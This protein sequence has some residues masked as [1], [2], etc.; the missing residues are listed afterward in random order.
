MGEDGKE[1][2]Y[3]RGV[4]PPKQRRSE[5]T[6]DRLLDG[7]ESLLDGRDFEDIPVLEIAETAGIS[8]SSL[9]ARFKN[10]TVLLECLYER[11]MERIRAQV[12]D[13]DTPWQGFT[14]EEI[15]RELARR[16][17]QHRR[18]HTGFLRTMMLVELRDPRFRL[19]RLKADAL[20]YGAVRDFVLARWPGSDP[21]ERRRQVGFVLQLVQAALQNLFSTPEVLAEAIDADDAWI[22]DEIA[23]LILRYLEVAP[24]GD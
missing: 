9:Y 19:W 24:R 22:A 2:Q 12:L 14:P 15:G 18:V 13:D 6:L 20:H 17:I 7:A 11:H 8:V 1:R 16:Y 3:R 5:E 4:H 23:R 21:E 10:K